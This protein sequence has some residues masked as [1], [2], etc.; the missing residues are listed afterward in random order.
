MTPEDE[1]VIRQHAEKFYG[2]KAE[3]DTLGQSQ[4]PTDSAEAIKQSIE[5][6]VLR[7]KMLQ[8]Q[9]SLAEAIKT[10]SSKPE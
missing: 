7:T 3:F 1:V 2:L 9:T 4:M 8:A 6:E 10:I 5:F